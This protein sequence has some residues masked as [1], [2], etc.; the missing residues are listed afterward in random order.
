MG[1]LEVDSTRRLELRCSNCHVRRS[2]RGEFFAH[3][4][5]LPIAFQL[6]Y[7]VTHRWRPVQVFS[8]LHLTDKSR[9]RAMMDN[10]GRICRFF[11]EFKFKH[12]LGRWDHAM[13]DEAATGQAKKAKSGMA[14]RPT[15]AGLRWWLSM[16]NTRTN[17]AGGPRKCVSFFFEL[18]PKLAYEKNGTTKFH[19]KTKEHLCWWL[20][21]LL[22]WNATLITDSALAY[23]AMGEEYRPDVTHLDCN[24]SVGFA[25][26]GPK[27]QLLN[28]SNGAVCSNAVEGAHSALF[29][30]IRQWLG[31]KI[32][33]GN[34]EHELLIKDIGVSML[35]WN[36][37]HQDATQEVFLWMRYLYGSMEVTKFEEQILE[38]LL[39]QPGP[40]PDYVTLE[41][42]YEAIDIQQ[43]D[44]KFLVGPPLPE[45]RKSFSTA[46]E[47]FAA[48]WAAHIGRLVVMQE[49]ELEAEVDS[50]GEMAPASYQANRAE[51]EC[52]FTSRVLKETEAA[53]QRTPKRRRG[54]KAKDKQRA[55]HLKPKEEAPVG[56]TRQTGI[57]GAAYKPNATKKKETPAVSFNAK[58]TGQVQDPQGRR[59]TGVFGAKY[60]PNKDKE[61][62]E[63]AVSFNPKHTT[64]VVDAAGLKQPEIGP[65]FVNHQRRFDLTND[66]APKC[67]FFKTAV[68]MSRAD[69]KAGWATP[70][71]R[72]LTAEM[73][74]ELH[75]PSSEARA[76]ARRR[77][78]LRDIQPESSKATA[79]KSPHIDL[80]GEPT[81]PPRS[82][83]ELHSDEKIGCIRRVENFSPVPFWL[84]EE[85]KNSKNGKNNKKG[86]GQAKQPA[87]TPPLSPPPSPPSLSPPPVT[88]LTTPPSPPADLTTGNEDPPR[89]PPWHADYPGGF[90]GSPSP[91]KWTCVSG[92]PENSVEWEL[93]EHERR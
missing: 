81:T 40:V 55:S 80:T 7:A 70:T 43:E 4:K 91:G 12:S 60:A 77:P 42:Q 14:K 39:L 58:H 31:C 45:L 34:E 23:R 75:G 53:S 66:E 44:W 20:Q 86:R 24:H 56:G 47:N 6:I 72:D 37:N 78:V 50:D 88:D 82:A 1:K 49:A 10:V 73:E 8:E 65:L 90:L 38:E 13:A 76:A 30:L 46:P 33:K 26:P 41:A 93:E 3:Y 64:A 27:S 18:I 74:A 84:G 11:L 5:S 28:L 67:G 48:D 51:V 61:N 29:R 15:K 85:P 22:A 83:R 16:V 68:V 17:M 25:A 32:G 79:L 63:A 54:K 69:M 9:Y 2:A 92:D 57:F 21:R 52:A 87:G 35:N 62:E 89:T 36:W 71:K 59:Q 19:I